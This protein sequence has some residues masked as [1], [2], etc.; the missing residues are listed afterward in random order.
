MKEHINGEKSDN[1][2]DDLIKEY[3]EKMDNNAGKA[4]Q[5]FKYKDSKGK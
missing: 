1:L 3:I 5:F 2:N 4:I